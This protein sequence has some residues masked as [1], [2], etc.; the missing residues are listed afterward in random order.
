MAGIIW[1][2]KIS[3]AQ[4]GCN[5]KGCAVAEGETSTCNS[6]QTVCQGA[7]AG[8][9]GW[10]YVGRMGGGCGRRGRGGFARVFCLVALAHLFRDT[11]DYITVPDKPQIF[12]LGRLGSDEF[13][14]SG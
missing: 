3:S 1:N 4:D 13:V 2:K 7:G 11:A 9:E 5:V 6:G 10:G 12:R 14:P 8:V